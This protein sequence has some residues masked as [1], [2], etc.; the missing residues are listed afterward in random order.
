MNKETRYQK[1]GSVKL[2]IWMLLIYAAV[3]AILFICNLDYPIFLGIL[4]VFNVFFVIYCIIV[5]SG[6]VKGKRAISKENKSLYLF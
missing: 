4:I 1:T 5:L 2:T 6:V 3:M